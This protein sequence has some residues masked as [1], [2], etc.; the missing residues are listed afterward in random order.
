MFIGHYG[1][2]AAAKRSRP[3][4][5]L[6]ALFVAVQFLDVVFAVLVLA[7][8]E[9]LRIVPGFTAYNPYDLYW[10]PYSHSLL[11]ALVWSGLFAASAFFW[12]RRAPVPQR[13]GASLILG[14]AVFSHFLLDI[15]MHTADL[16]LGFGAG[17]PKIGLGLWNHRAI[18]T[19]AELAVLFAGG[20]LYLRGS[21]ARTPGARTA[22]TV[23]GVV[24]VLLTLVTPFMPDPSSGSAFAVQAL[25]SY[26]VLAAAAEWVGRRRVPAGYFEA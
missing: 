24:L 4:L 16:P 10:M 20:L 19:A 15:P 18:A 8:I 11:G 5:S 26:L 23:F 9:K 21:R 22:T 12:Y 3:L 7:G 25:A 2:A 14:A 17:S 13:A 6:G 1:V